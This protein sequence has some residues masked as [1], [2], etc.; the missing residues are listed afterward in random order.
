VVPPKAAPKN[1]EVLSEYEVVVDKDRR[2]VQVSDSFCNLLG[3]SR[4]QLVSKKYDVVTAPRTNHIPV[5][6]ELLMK[7]GYMHG[8]WIFVYGRQSGRLRGAMP[9]TGPGCGCL[10]DCG[11]AWRRGVNERLSSPLAIAEYALSQV[12]RHHNC[13]W[14]VRSRLRFNGFESITNKL[15]SPSFKIE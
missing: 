10:S 12:G 11:S 3:Y 13:L 2:Y 5:V 9:R 1:A 14:R 8:I 15:F 7:S 6:F 4:D